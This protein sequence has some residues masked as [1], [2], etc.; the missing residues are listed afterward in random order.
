M[1]M[2]TFL[3]TLNSLP[4]KRRQVVSRIREATPS[5]YTHTHTCTYAYVQIHEHIRIYIYRIY[6][7]VYMRACMHDICVDA[8]GQ[9]AP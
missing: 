7:N 9:R 2:L 5:G 3:R 1:A 4:T 6:I 8:Y